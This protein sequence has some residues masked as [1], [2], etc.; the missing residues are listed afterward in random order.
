MRAYQKQS[1]L[2]IV[3]L[4]SSLSVAEQQ[5]AFDAAPQGGYKLVLS[6]NI[7]ETSVTIGT[8]HRTALQL[9]D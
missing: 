7:A 1:A 5:R 9:V 3:P 8:I 4:H 6:T 2:L